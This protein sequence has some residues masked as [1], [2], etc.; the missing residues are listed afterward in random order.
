MLGFSPLSAA[1]L[2]ASS[3]DAAIV[4]LPSQVLNKVVNDLTLEAKANKTIASVFSSFTVNSV[5][6]DAEANVTSNAVTASFTE[7]TLSF[8]GLANITPSSVTALTNA[9]T[10]GFDAKGITPSLSGLSSVT[11][12]SALDFDAEANIT[13]GSFNLLTTLVD[14]TTFLEV[15]AATE[16]TSLLANFNLNLDAPADNLF[17][18]DAVADNYNISRTVFILSESF[19]LGNTVH[20]PP[21]NFTISMTD[22]TLGLENN[23]YISPED[24]TVYIQDYKD[25]PTTVLITQ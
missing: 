24:F 2:S 6:F 14:I 20:I 21:E 25:T 17:N 5:D 11:S 19:G 16:L 15:D 22:P 4:T 3:D 18:Y 13:T 8:V 10:A 12:I 23:I 1:P 9:G 7:G